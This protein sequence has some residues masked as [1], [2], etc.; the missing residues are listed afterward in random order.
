VEPQLVD[1]ERLSRAVAQAN[2]T[3]LISS[4]PNGIHT[5]LG[6]RKDSF[7]GGQL[8]RI[9]LARALYSE[10]RM[11]IMDE[12]TSALDANSENEINIALDAMRGKVTVILIAHRLNTVQRSDV[13]FLLEKGNVTASG[14][15]P[16]LLRTN[17]TVRQLA[18]L[19]SIASTE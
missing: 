16:E 14:T 2:L 11:L 19:M 9:G 12:A 17:E 4:L 6:K 13:V 1:K 18:K 7:S 10:P 5:S 15:F 8:Q 3:D